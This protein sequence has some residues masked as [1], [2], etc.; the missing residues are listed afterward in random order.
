MRILCRKWCTMFCTY[1]DQNF[2]YISYCYMKHSIPM[3]MYF[4]LVT[5]VIVGWWEMPTQQHKSVSS[6]TCLQQQRLLQHLPSEKNHTHV[7]M[8]ITIL[9]YQVHD[10][11]WMG[12]TQCMALRDKEITKYSSFDWNIAGQKLDL[13]LVGIIFKSCIDS[14]TKYFFL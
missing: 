3:M 9:T 1:Y 8:W 11:W 10:S 2:M 4:E 5:C 12:S 14:K 13:W 7:D 6:S